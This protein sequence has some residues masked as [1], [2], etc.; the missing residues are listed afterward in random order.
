MASIS[1]RMLVC[2]QCPVCL[3]DYFFLLKGRTSMKRLIPLLQSLLRIQEVVLLPPQRARSNGC[4]SLKCIDRSFSGTP[5][6]P[7]PT[8]KSKRRIRVAS[9]SFATW[10]SLRMVFSPFPCHRRCARNACGFSLCGVVATHVPIHPA[11]QELPLLC[12]ALEGSIAPVAIFR[13]S[14]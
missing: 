8:S 10:Y 6:P 14:T 3:S 11:A 1:L 9:A 12:V 2:L 4:G 5:F 7:S 13:V